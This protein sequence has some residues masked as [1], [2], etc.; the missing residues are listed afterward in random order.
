[1][2]TATEQYVPFALLSEMLMVE[3]KKPSLKK[4]ARS[5]YHRDYLKTKNKPYRKYDKTKRENQSGE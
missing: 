2:T 4:A 5:V 3:E 1:M